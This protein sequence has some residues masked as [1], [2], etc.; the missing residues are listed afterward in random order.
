MGITEI[1]LNGTAIPAKTFSCNASVAQVKKPDAIRALKSGS[2]EVS[3]NGGEWISVCD[4][5]KYLRDAYANSNRGVASVS[6]NAGDKFLS[7][8]NGYRDTSF[9]IRPA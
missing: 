2:W 8:H 7:F 6:H 3:V 1:N 4:A 9:R 5:A